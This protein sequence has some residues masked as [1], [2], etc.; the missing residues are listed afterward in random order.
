MDVNENLVLTDMLVLNKAQYVKHM[1]DTTGMPES[2]ASQDFED[3]HERQGTA[4][5][6]EEEWHVEVPDIKRK[7]KTEGTRTE[8]AMV[9]R[10]RLNPPSPAPTEERR[11]GRSLTEAR[12][13][14][15]DRRVSESDRSRSRVRDRDTRPSLGGQQGPGTVPG[16]RSLAASTLPWAGDVAAVLPTHAC[17]TPERSVQTRDPN[18][19]SGRTKLIEATIEPLFEHEEFTTRNHTNSKC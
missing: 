4:N 3:L 11:R 8:H 16:A 9:T 2:V 6:E 14:D 19:S 10:R 5:D 1:G 15:H 17:R 7:R 18:S 12:L 13:R